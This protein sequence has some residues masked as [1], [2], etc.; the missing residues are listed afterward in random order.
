[1]NVKQNKN[2]HLFGHLNNVANFIC[3]FVRIQIELF[4]LQGSFPFVPTIHS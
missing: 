3:F 4:K 1:M 2:F